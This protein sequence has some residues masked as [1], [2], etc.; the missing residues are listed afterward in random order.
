ML[1]E[2]CAICGGDD[3]DCDHCAAC[4]APRCRSCREAGE[5][6]PCDDEDTEL[7]L[8]DRSE[9]AD[10]GGESALRAATPDNPRVF[11]CP[12]CGQPNRLT[13]QDV[14]RH[15]QC[16]DCADKEEAGVP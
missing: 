4:G 11:P 9:F 5:E 3:D 16:D 7:D 8:E 1:C 12:T 15:Y 14:Q 6:C 10:P 13:G 2:T